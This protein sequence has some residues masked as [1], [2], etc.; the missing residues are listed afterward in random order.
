MLKFL[1]LYVDRFVFLIKKI[2]FDKLQYKQ[3]F[4]YH[5]TQELRDGID[6][7]ITKEIAS[8]DPVKI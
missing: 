8:I 6:S 3:G 4:L 5:L 1:K 2:V 7:N